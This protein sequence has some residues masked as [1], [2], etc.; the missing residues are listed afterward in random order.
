MCPMQKTKRIKVTPRPGSRKYYLD[1]QP[2]LWSELADW[3]KSSR[4]IHWLALKSSAMPKKRRKLNARTPSEMK[5]VTVN[6]AGRAIGEDHVNAKYLD[7]DVEHA[8][9]LVASGQYTLREISQMLDMPIRT[10]RD[11][12]KGTRRNQ[13]V[14]GWKKIRRYKKE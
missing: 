11:Y 6:D 1:R 13:S 14:A 9:E 3:P 12:A 4:K 5:M 10:I 2:F 7:E 8:R